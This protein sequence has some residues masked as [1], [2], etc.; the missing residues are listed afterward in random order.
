MEQD[1]KRAND[2]AE[3]DALTKDEKIKAR[4]DARKKAN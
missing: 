3:A 1:K 2:K 4:L